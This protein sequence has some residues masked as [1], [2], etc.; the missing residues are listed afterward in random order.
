MHIIHS[1]LCKKCNSLSPLLL[2]FYTELSAWQLT[3]SRE[4]VEIQNTPLQTA[5]YS[6]LYDRFVRYT[7]INLFLWAI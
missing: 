1:D 4:G 7:Y 3:K 5:E 2:N 6:D